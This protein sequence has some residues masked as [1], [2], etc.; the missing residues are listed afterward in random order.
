MPH[1]P[2]PVAN[3]CIDHPSFRRLSP[4]QYLMK[5]PGSQLHITLHVGQIADI[6]KFDEQVRLRNGIAT[7]QHIPIG[8]AE[9]S[10]A[11]NTGAHPED[12]RRISKVFLG[13]SATENIIEA[14][15]DPPYLCDFYITAEQVGLESEISSALLTE[16]SRE[17]A[18]TYV[19]KRKYE[20]QGFFDRKEKRLQAFATR[21][22]PQFAA[23]TSRADFQ[24]KRRPRRRFI[25]GDDTPLPSSGFSYNELFAS[26]ADNY[27]APTDPFTEME[28]AKIN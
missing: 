5:S 8:F 13:D 6:L 20:R 1:P 15:A 19:H 14:S 22:S 25:S 3:Q 7:L 4:T 2:G 16:M 12:E 10:V 23:T 11:W 28:I 26:A 21:P 17:L 18:T 24:A 27:A 9:F